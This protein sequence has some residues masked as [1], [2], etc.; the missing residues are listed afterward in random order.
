M[1]ENDA[2]LPCTVHVGF[3]RFEQGVK[4]KTLQDCINRLHER[5]VT[6]ER[7]VHEMSDLCRR[8]IHNS[9]K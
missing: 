2:T 6:M 9:V 7:A 3:V 8:T 4:V 5:T 1:N